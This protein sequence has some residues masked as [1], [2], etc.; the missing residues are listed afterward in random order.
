MDEIG[1]RPIG[2]IHSRYESTES[3]PIQSV[4][5]DDM[6]EVEIFPEYAGGLSDLDGF[7]HIIVI[8]HLHLSNEYF[9]MVRPPHDPVK[10]G[11]FS[12]R[13]PRRPNPIGISV[14]RLMGIRDN[15]LR[16]S[17]TDAVDGTPVLDIKPYI[18]ACDSVEN[19]AKIGWL[20]GKTAKLD[21]TQKS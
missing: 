12:T 8:Y 3:A 5:S 17:G 11:V 1:Y 13:S 20:E 19:G 16:I 6:A 15:R 2:V 18:P 21:L 7:S 4:L 14:V 9:L 10:R